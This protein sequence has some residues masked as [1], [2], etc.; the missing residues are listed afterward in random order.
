MGSPMFAPCY[1]ADLSKSMY[2][3]KRGMRYVEA[4]DMSSEQYFK[5][6][7]VILFMG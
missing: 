7:H 6:I 5:K 1:L 3:D 2:R 4:N